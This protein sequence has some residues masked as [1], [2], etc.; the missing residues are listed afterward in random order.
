MYWKQRASKPQ[1]CGVGRKRRRRLEDILQHYCT[2]QHLDNTC[3]GE[4][5]NVKIV[6]KIPTAGLHTCFQ[7]WRE[8]RMIRWHCS[9]GRHQIVSDDVQASSAIVGSCAADGHERVLQEH[10]HQKVGIGNASRCRGYQGQY[11]KR[12]RLRLLKK[13][14]GKNGLE[15]NL[16]VTW[17]VGGSGL[18]EWHVNPERRCEQRPTDATSGEGWRS[19]AFPTIVILKA[20]SFSSWLASTVIIYKGRVRS[21]R[22]NSTLRGASCCQTFCAS[23]MHGMY[24]DLRNRK[25]KAPLRT[26]GVQACHGLVNPYHLQSS[27]TQADVEPSPL[28]GWLLPTLEIRD[29]SQGNTNQVGTPARGLT[30]SSRQSHGSQGSV[31]F[32]QVTNLIASESPVRAGRPSPSIPLEPS[33]GAGPPLLPSALIGTG[34]HFDYSFRADSLVSE[35]SSA[36]EA[37]EVHSNVTQSA[38]S[39]GTRVRLLTGSTQTKPQ[40]QQRTEEGSTGEV[41]ASS[42]SSNHPK[43]IVSN[44]LKSMENVPSIGSDSV[45]EKPLDP[46]FVRGVQRFNPVKPVSFLLHELPTLGQALPKKANHICPAIFELVLLERALKEML[47]VDLIGLRAK[48]TPLVLEGITVDLFEATTPTA[49]LLEAIPPTAD[50]FEATLIADLLLETVLPTMVLSFRGAPPTG[51]VLESLPFPFVIRLTTTYRLG[52][53]FIQSPNLSASY[54]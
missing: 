27:E 22:Q 24:E 2:L 21:F 31:I 5:T 39:P 33:V 25:E 35:R 44:R 51:V 52:L 46:G 37:Q 29:Y 53:A 7:R 12:G 26:D 23:T 34:L 13:W 28:L 40:A 4:L 38:F 54:A 41:L 45:T 3:K 19:M 30:S 15:V 48:A 10:K 1:F 42:N 16:R 49:D 36:S 8:I 20:R 14:E 9:P 32:P 47:Q 50:P 43:D 6:R 11:Q 18:P 17:T